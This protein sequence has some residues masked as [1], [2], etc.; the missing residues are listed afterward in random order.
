M[1]FPVNWLLKQVLCIVTAVEFPSNF[2]ACYTFHFPFCFI[3]FV[4]EKTSSQTGEIFLNQS[5]DKN[6][7]ILV[8]Y[9]FEC[10]WV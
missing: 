5:Y 4:Q 7:R 1:V 2:L 10:C 9:V 8:T 6:M 3:L